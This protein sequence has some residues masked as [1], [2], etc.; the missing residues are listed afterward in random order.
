ML[1]SGGGVALVKACKEVKLDVSDDI[2]KTAI[3]ILVPLISCFIS[4]TAVTVIF[5]PMIGKVR[6]VEF[7]PPKYSNMVV[8]ISILGDRT[9]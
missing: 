2:P 6:N 9:G 1:F 5:L 8:S 7:I 4:H 3:F